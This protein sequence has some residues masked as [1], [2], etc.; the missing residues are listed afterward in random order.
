MYLSRPAEYALRASTYLTRLGPGE[1]IT[2][3]QLAQAVDVPPAFLSK[4]MRRLTANG[5]VDSKKGHHGGFVLAKPPEEIRFLDILRA[6]EFG[7]IKDHCLFGLGN[8]DESNPCPLHAEWEILKQQIEQWARTH[9]LG[10]SL[11][12]VQ[13]FK[14]K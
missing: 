9:T 3:S 11:S 10:E 4:I 8:C 5:I 14:Q 2:S 7:P 13:A 6:V 1:R 12:A